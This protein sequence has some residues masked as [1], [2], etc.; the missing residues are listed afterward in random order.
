LNAQ[1]TAAFEE[2]TEAR[3][4]AEKYVRDTVLFATILF[5]IALSQR[6]RLRNVRIGILVVAGGLMIVAVVA[7]V[8]LPHA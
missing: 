4:T 8:R 1:A 3:D 2:G 5:L 7:V 6:F